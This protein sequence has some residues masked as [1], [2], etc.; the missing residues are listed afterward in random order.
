MCNDYAREIE[1]GR[2]IAALEEMK[3]VPPFAY[4]GGRI[5]NDI[6]P[7][8]HIKI[9]DRGLVVRLKDN[10]LESEMM[11]WAWFQGK[12]PVFNFASEKRDLSNSDRVVILAT[13]FYEYTPPEER[14]PKIKLQDQHQFTLQSADWFW[15]AGIVKEECFAMLTVA[16]GTDVAPYHDRQIVVLPPAKAMDWLA[17]KKPQP[18][19][20]KALSVGSLRHHLLRRNGVVLQ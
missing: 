3:H 18:D 4:T 19:V 1:A 17:L 5:P 12:K 10:R 9:R 6:A 11:T 20:L 14:K 8:P 16:P 13:S 2:V 7:A 15:I